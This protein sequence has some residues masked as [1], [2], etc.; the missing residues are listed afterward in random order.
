MR[1]YAARLAYERRW[2]PTQEVTVLDDTG[3]KVEVRFEVGRLE[4]VMLCVLSFVARR[5]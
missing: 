1:N 2:H 4:V 5:R 3:N